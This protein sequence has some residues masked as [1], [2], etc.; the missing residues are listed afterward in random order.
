MSSTVTP[1]ARARSRWTKTDNQHK[2]ESEKSS[3]EVSTPLLGFGYSLAELRLKY[4]QAMAYP[5]PCLSI[6]G[7]CDSVMYVGEAEH[8]CEA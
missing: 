8:A 6:L 1:R 2:L 7:L 4:G 5:S 3:M